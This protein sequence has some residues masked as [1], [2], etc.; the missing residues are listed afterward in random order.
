MKDANNGLEGQ[1]KLISVN[2]FNGLQGV[3][4]WRDIYLAR[5]LIN[6]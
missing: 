1:K 6:E 5:F 4:I 3:L 2:V